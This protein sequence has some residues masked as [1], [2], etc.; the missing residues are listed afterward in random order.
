MIIQDSFDPFMS[1]LNVKLIQECKGK[2]RVNYLWYSWSS[3]NINFVN[4]F[5]FIF[6]FYKYSCL[7]RFNLVSSAKFGIVIDYSTLIIYPQ[8]LSPERDGAKLTQSL[9]SA[10]HQLHLIGTMAIIQ[11]FPRLNF[12]HAGCFLSLCL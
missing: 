8:V 10:A 1:L 4:F 3:N 12:I 5:F 7:F 9:T 2:V 6:I 11:T